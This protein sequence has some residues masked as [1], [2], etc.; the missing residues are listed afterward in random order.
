MNS[1][2]YQLNSI[3]STIDKDQLTKYINDE[4]ALDQLV[5]S[6]DQYQAL[7]KEKEKIQHNNKNLAESNLN[8]EPVLQQLRTELSDA[9]REFDQAKK[10]FVSLKETYDVQMGASGNVSLES[11]LNLLQTD[12][13]KA[14]EDT[15]KSADDF[16]SDYNNMRTEEELNMFQK[17]FLDNRAQAYMKK[18]KAEKM[19]ELIPNYLIK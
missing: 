12:A 15:E 5:K 6:L 8:K 18:I 10:E 4:A 1:Y 11:L 13:A 16:F 14:E 19:K 3:L 2:D 7:I 17:Q 9:M